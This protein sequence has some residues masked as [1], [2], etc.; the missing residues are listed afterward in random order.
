MRNTLFCF[1][2]IGN[3]AMSQIT[4][5]K[6]GEQLTYSTSYQISG[7]YTNIAEINL[8]VFSTFTKKGNMLKLKGTAKTFSNFDSFFKIRDLYESVADPDN[9]NPLTFTRDIEEGPYSK[10]FLYS[11]NHNAKIASGK[12]TRKGKNRNYNVSIPVGCH[13]MI[14]ALYY[15]RA[16]N[17]SVLKPGNKLILK[18]LIDDSVKTVSLNYNG[19]E[20][21]STVL[22]SKSCYKFSA[23][24]PGGTFGTIWFTADN[25]KIPVSIEAKIPV[26]KGR[27]TLTRAVGI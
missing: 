5:F 3:F 24:Y 11:F 10:T 23:S 6:S 18:V 7:L 13:D 17:L 21:L 27:I 16:I 26:G 15:V 4:A 1:L 20:T 9:L 22:G 19:K 25:A 14:S 12:E 8:S 2:F